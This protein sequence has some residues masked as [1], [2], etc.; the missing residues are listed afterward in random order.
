MLNRGNTQLVSVFTI[1]CDISFLC[2]G[3]G[4]C[5]INLSNS[6]FG[7]YGLVSRGASEILYRG[8]VKKS[9][10]RQITFKNLAK[11]PNIGDGVLFAN[12]NQATCNRDNGLVVDSLAQDLLYEGT[13]QST[14]AGLRY[15]AKGEIT[16]G[17]QGPE[18]VAALDHAKY[19]AGLIT[20]DTA[21]TATSGNTETQVR[22]STLGVSAGTST[23]QRLVRDGFA[24]VSGIVKNGPLSPQTI[25]LP[26]Y[27]LAEP[28][29]KRLREQVLSKKAEIQDQT[30]AFV[31]TN[32]PTLQYAES[33]CFRD[34]GIIIDAVVNDMIFGGNYLS[35]KAARTYIN[36]NGLV[37]PA[38][39]TTATV[40][41]VKF[42][43]DKVI[44]LLTEDTTA[45]T[46]ATANFALIT[47]SIDAGAVTAAPQ[48]PE[49]QDTNVDIKNLVANLQANK[50]LVETIIT[51]YVNTN[52]PELVGNYSVSTCRR[53]I[54]YVLDAMCFD[55]AYGGNSETLDSAKRYYG[56]AN[57]SR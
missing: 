19:V 17:D 13:T 42:A 47:S 52:Y 2:E 7:N 54:G 56:Y 41:A 27:D 30:I 50:V 28:E 51:D 14:F 15:W 38:N 40:E 33:K 34:V 3:G 5:S 8:V 9:A 10:G 32:Y 35:I 11:R 26:D 29:L 39:T 46:R 18:T 31:K 45:T 20:R 53:D 57:G 43:R 23:P 44:A 16:I 36:T 1:C 4:F 24:I 25:I 49:Y 37:I 48:Y 55:L 6:S 21:I 22:A 12:Y